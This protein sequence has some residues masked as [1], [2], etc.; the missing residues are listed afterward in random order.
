MLRNV[1]PSNHVSSICTCRQEVP[2]DPDTLL[3]KLVNSRHLA[4]NI[5]QFVL[6]V[7]QFGFDGLF[8]GRLDYQDKDARMKDKTMEMIWHGSPENLG[9]QTSLNVFLLTHIIT[10]NCLSTQYI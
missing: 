9:T 2:G 7:F 8:F 4:I 5:V 6:F 3:V 10:V 1:L